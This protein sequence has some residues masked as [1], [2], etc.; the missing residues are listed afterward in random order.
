MPPE[1]YTWE[2][3]QSPRGFFLVFY[4]IKTYLAYG[5]LL[6]GY[7][8]THVGTFFFNTARSDNSIRGTGFSVQTKRHPLL[9]VTTQF[10][11]KRRTILLR[12]M[13]LW[14]FF[15]IPVLLSLKF[16]KHD[17][18]GILLLPLS[19]RFRKG[20]VSYTNKNGNTWQKTLCR[21]C[22]RMIMKWKMA[23]YTLIYTIVTMMYWN[24]ALSYF[25]LYTSPLENQPIL[26]F[27]ILLLEFFSGKK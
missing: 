12:I 24:S 23:R 10:L 5:S 13:F 26:K 4:E 15:R 14:Y 2:N 19:Y 11:T 25:L 16:R 6:I 3:F 7:I 27:F 20:I 21:M 18:Y 8:I 1:G 22:K 17:D 9:A